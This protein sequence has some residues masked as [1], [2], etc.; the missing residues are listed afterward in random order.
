MAYAIDYETFIVQV[1]E[2]L[3]YNRPSITSPVL[4]I[5]TT[6]THGRVVGLLHVVSQV[7]LKDAQT[8]KL[9]SKW[10]VKHEKWFP[11]QFRVTYTG[12]KRWIV[13]QLLKKKDRILFMVEDLSG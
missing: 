5:I 13:T 10:R 8:I 7:M 12:T 6:E 3:K 11:S 9:M 1:V 2:D 4:P